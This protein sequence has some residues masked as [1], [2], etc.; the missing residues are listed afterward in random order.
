MDNCILPVNLQRRIN[1][2]INVNQ[3][4]EDNQECQKNGES[5]NG[6]VSNRTN[7]YGIVMI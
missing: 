7:L 2:L 3:L 6:D 5:Q 1:R 4:N